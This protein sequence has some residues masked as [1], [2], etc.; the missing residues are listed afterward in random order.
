MNTSYFVCT[1]VLE[2]LVKVSNYFST[3]EIIIKENE[4]VLLFWH[5]MV[6]FGN[7]GRIY[8]CPKQR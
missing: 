2:C 7:G 8:A 3:K 4:V 6:L 5:E 1:I